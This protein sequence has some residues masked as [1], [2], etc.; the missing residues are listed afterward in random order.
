M[1]AIYSNEVICVDHNRVVVLEEL[2]N[3]L[4]RVRIKVER[5][6][7]TVLLSTRLIR[8]L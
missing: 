3:D 6:L 1:A 8:T 7:E 4:M 5:V 2:P